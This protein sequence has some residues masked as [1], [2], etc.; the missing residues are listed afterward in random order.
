MK[1]VIAAGISAL[2][3]LAA[4]ALAPPSGTIMP[5]DVAQCQAQPDVPWCRAQCEKTPSWE[6][7]HAGQ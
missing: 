2:L 3:T 5:Q 7:C 1:Y 4:C 6:G